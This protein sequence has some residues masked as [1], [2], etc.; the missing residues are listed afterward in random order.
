MKR[1]EAKSTL[2]KEF[3][4]KF[5][6][7]TPISITN[8]NDFFF[9]TGIKTTKPTTS[10][11]VRF[12]VQNNDTSTPT[13]GGVGARR[14]GRLGF[15]AA[16]VFIPENDGTKN[17]DE[18]CE[19]IIDIFEGNRFN[20]IVCETGTYREAGNIENNYFTYDVTIFYRFHECK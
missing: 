2:L 19:E 14:F 8:K 10:P 18:L 16:Q 20:E 11:Y 6:T 13:I 3:L 15:I 4:D 5:N 1:S 12:W 17:G 9:S 7:T